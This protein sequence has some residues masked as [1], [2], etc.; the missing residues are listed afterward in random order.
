MVA[1]FGYGPGVIGN[2]I[3]LGFMEFENWVFFFS[4]LVNICNF[5][6]TGKIHGGKCLFFC[7]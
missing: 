6:K 3:A 2:R 1:G 5:T 4:I 7:F